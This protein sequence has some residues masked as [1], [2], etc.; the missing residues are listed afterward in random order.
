MSDFD[1]HFPLL[2]AKNTVTDRVSN[3]FEGTLL[4]IL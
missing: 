2:A 1:L 4:N 3:T